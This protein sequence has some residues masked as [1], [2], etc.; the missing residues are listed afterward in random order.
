MAFGL[1]RRPPTAVAKAPTMVVVRSQPLLSEL[2]W[3]LGLGILIWSGE[4][5]KKEV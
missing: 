2:P 4:G 1:R 3:P 5:K